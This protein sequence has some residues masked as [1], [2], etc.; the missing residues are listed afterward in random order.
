MAPWMKRGDREFRVGEAEQA[1]APKGL[2][3]MGGAGGA[4]RG[5]RGGGRRGGVGRGRWGGTSGA[6]RGQWGGAGLFCAQLKFK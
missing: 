2:G 6:G 5:R 4:G 1:D 3:L